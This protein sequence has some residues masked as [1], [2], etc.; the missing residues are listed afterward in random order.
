MMLTVIWDSE[1]IVLIEFLKQGNAVNS[2]R[3]IST[4]RRLRVRLKR[5]RPAKHAILHHDN[6]RPHTSRHT[7]EALH[8]MNFIVL[9]HPFYRPDFALKFHRIAPSVLQ[10]RPCAK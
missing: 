9:P 3:Y 8:K 6:A 10:P 4:L 2:E 1:G 5:V 7:E